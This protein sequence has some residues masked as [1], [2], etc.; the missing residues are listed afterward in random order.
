MAYLDDLRTV[1]IT[2]TRGGVPATVEVVGGS[3]R[4]VPFFVESHQFGTGRR[5]AV[6]EYPG[7]DDPFNE[8]MGR[9]SRSVTLAGYLVG[10]DVKAQKDQL[11]EAMEK[12]GSGKLVHPYMG[13]KN[14]QPAGLQISESAKEKRWVGL[15]LSFVLDPDVKPTPILTVDRKAA[16]TLKGAAGLSQVA[17]KFPEKFSL[18]GAAKATI[19]AAVKLTDKLLDQVESARGTMRTAAAYKSKMLQIRQ[20]LE[21]ALLAPADFAARV[22]ELLTMTDGAL[23]PSGT[24][25]IRLVTSS[26]GGS[27]QSLPA[28]DQ[29][30]TL[31]RFQLSEAI[32]MISAGSS[33]AAVPNQAATE[34]A[35]EAA[36][37]AALLDLFQQTALFSTASF[38][39]DAEVSSVQDAGALQ[40]SLSDSFDTV[41][42]GTEDPD[43]YQAVQDL[44]ANA[45][46]FLR[47]T[48]ADLAVVLEYTPRRTAPA[49]VLSHE[50]YGS[51]ERVPDL[52][53]RN[54][55]QAPGFV[56]GGQPLEILSR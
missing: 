43:I 25:S 31:A 6:H 41:M 13:T 2:I 15:S 20:N 11:L 17:K 5:I 10:E 56:Q 23:I 46:A 55:I 47:E 32:T 21:L 24:P 54:A 14:A 3:F 19:D 51:I 18:L 44:Q 4:G 1:K 7:L 28:E 45:L 12:G 8:D 42:E 40:G 35:K 52:M 36:N 29:A 26:A 38:L 34:R 49:L 50:L 30:S 37:Q 53:A 16:S 33:T 39:V 22:Q 9:V 27:V 48:S